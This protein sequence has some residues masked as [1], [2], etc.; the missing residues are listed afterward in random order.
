MMPAPANRAS[1]HP[2]TGN[3]PAQFPWGWGIGILTACHGPGGS[4]VF[5]VD[6]LADRAERF[7]DRLAL[8]ID[9]ASGKLDKAA[10]GRMV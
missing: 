6:E 1:L 2:D 7:G 3:F 10:I 5:A 8:R 4:E 9:G